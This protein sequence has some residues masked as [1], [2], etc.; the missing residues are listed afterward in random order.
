MT[1]T[2]K[3]KHFF[4]IKTV[5]VEAGACTTALNMVIKK[6]EVLNRLHK[7]SCSFTENYLLLK[8]LFKYSVFY[9]V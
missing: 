9:H 4:M 7:W 1:K 6:F 5:G 3:K 8:L 2:I